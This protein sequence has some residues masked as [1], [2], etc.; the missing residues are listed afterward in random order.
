MIDAIARARRTP[1]RVLGLTFVVVLLAGCA[2]GPPSANDPPAAYETRGVE[3]LVQLADATL[4]G[5]DAAAALDLYRRAVETAPDDVRARLALA[6]AYFATGAML[7]ARVAFA[8]LGELA[9]L[10][11]E[12]GL[13]RVALA[14]GDAATAREQFEAALARAPDNVRALNGAAVALDFQGRHEAAQAHY[15]HALELQPTNRKIANNKALSLMLAGRSESAIAELEDLAFGALELPQARHNLAL[16]YGLAGDEDAA[17]ALIARDL[18]DTAVNRN[19]EFYRLAR[20]LD[21]VAPAA[22]P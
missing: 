10:E 2:S 3:N 5:G 12:I 16:A 20:G 17:E 8:A 1:R 21:T 11:V 7:E 14:A 22:G 19:L 4:A 13:G 9:P 18:D 15:A 6:N